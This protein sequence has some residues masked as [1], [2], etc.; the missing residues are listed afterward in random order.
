MMRHN[1]GG[2]LMG[3]G[4]HSINVYKPLSCDLHNHVPTLSLEFLL[5]QNTY[6]LFIDMSNAVTLHLE[7]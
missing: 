3:K 5:T 6:F 2:Y 4:N 1:Q 7:K